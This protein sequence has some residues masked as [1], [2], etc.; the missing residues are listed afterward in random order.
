MNVESLGGA[1]YFIT[2]I[3]DCIR[4]TETTMLRNRSD[5]LEA[6]KNYKQKVEKQTG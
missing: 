4:Y 2:F 6:F 1:K 3:D 5:A